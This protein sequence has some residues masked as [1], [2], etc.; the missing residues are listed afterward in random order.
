M[1]EAA[2]DIYLNR[3]LMVFDH[4]VFL[5]VIYNPIYHT[6]A[7]NIFKSLSNEAD[8]NFIFLQSSSD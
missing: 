2:S 6:L 8:I 7:E 4:V 5:L 1:L 3:C